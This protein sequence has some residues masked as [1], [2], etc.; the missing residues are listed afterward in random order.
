[1]GLDGADA[2]LEELGVGG[3]HL[4]AHGAFA[5]AAPTPLGPLPTEVVHAHAPAAVAEDAILVAGAFRAEVG[6]GDSV[7]EDAGGR[8]E[9]IEAAGFAGGGGGG[10]DEVEGAG[11]RY[12]VDV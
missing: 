12:P 3:M 8:D 4:E 10:T 11:G 1:F 5:A 9:V 2:D 7:L 6:V